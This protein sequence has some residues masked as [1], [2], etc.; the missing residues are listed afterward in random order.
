MMIRHCDL[1]KQIVH[2]DGNR[3]SFN[4]TVYLNEHGSREYRELSGDA[5]IKCFPADLLR[6]V[7]VY[8]QTCH[9]DNESIEPRVERADSREQMFASVNEDQVR[10]EGA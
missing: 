3:V 9:K 4:I 10:R 2:T 8:G 7:E 1:C 6:L 5:D